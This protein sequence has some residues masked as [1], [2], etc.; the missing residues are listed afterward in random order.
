MFSKKGQNIAEYAILIALVIAA[1][2]GM[3]V[4]VKRGW[5]GKVKDAT[6]FSV[7][8]EVIQGQPLLDFSTKQYE[9][10]YQKQESTIV[11]DRTLTEKSGAR[12]EISRTNVTE[13]TGR[14]KDSYDETLWE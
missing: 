3:Q 14:A 7:P 12:G 4:Y 5:Q 6:D 8:V 13:T 2:V 10:Y 1:A 11:S 9:P